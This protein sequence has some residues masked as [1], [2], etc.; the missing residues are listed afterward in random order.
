MSIMARIVSEDQ[1]KTHLI[2]GVRLEI[3]RE[4]LVSDR[5]FAAA[6]GMN[7][8]SALTNAL[9]MWNKARKK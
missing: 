2:L 7:L 5:S 3:D 1:S 4:A 8:V 6:L 9:T